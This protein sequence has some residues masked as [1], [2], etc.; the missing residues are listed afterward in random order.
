MIFERKYGNTRSIQS[1]DLFF[2]DH[3]DF[4]TKIEKSLRNFH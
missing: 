3:H 1:E 4:G 2:R